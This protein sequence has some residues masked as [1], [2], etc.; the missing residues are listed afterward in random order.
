MNYT[1]NKKLFKGDDILVVISQTNIT[2]LEAVNQFC[3]FEN[4]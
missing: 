3:W 1:I 4:F 2:K